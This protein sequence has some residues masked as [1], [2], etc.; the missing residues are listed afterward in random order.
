MPPNHDTILLSHL[1]GTGMTVHLKQQVFNQISSVYQTPT[2]A[3]AE[4]R[5]SP[6]LNHMMWVSIAGVN[7]LNNPL[8]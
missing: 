5:Q 6:Q 8:M 4:Q 3:T 1:D 2:I 7:A